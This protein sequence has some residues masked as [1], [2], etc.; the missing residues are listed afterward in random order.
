MVCFFFTVILSPSFLLNK[1]HQDFFFFQTKSFFYIVIF[2]VSRGLWPAPTLSHLL[3][4][5]AEQSPLHPASML[6]QMT[7]QTRQS[8]LVTN[9][10]TDWQVQGRTLH[11]AQR[12]SQSTL[13]SPG[14]RADAL[15]RW[16]RRVPPVLISGSWFHLGN[17]L[18][19]HYQ[20]WDQPLLMAAAYPIIPGL[21]SAFDLVC[22]T[23]ATSGRH[24]QLI[25]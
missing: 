13:A 18:L 23:V 10:H 7:G 12:I 16:T 24:L 3:S 25:N 2:V 14:W 22:T 4:V 21:I 19:N 1:T 20:G 5:L 9:A 17:R 8:L 11:R 15:H 6:V